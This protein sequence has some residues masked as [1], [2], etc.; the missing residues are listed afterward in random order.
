MSDQTIVTLLHARLSCLN[1]T[2]SLA[3]DTYNGPSRA[4]RGLI[5]GI[6]KLSRMLFGTAMD[7]D[8]EHLRERYNHQTSI[9]STNYRAIHINCPNI[10]RLEKHV[11]DLG[12]Y[13]NQ[14]KSELN[15]VLTSVDSMYD[16]VT[17]SQLLPV[18]ETAVNSLLHTNQLVVQNVVN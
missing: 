14:M 2:I 17:I 3:S 15:N 18:M 4:K 16:F 10:A 5:D 7:E 9:A 1:D 13:V 12:L 8:V 11:S 6:G